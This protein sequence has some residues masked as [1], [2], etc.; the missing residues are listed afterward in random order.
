LVKGKVELRDGKLQVLCETASEYKLDDLPPAETKSE[1]GAVQIAMADAEEAA[2]ADAV[3]ELDVDH[4][5]PPPEEPPSE[6]LKER[7]VP[8]TVAAPPTA[9]FVETKQEYLAKPS[10]GDAIA[11]GGTPSHAPIRHL[12]IFLERADDHDEEV[13]RMR[14]LLNLLRSFP[15]KD[16]FSFFVPNPQGMVQLDF[17]NF[18]TS[19]QV[20]EEPLAEMV[21]EW[22][23]FEVQ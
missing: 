12:R 7:P 8:D 10:A 17:P 19:C 11:Y 16:R 5:P 1:A 18:T 23:S 14:E 6:L 15:G 13:R 22:G 3:M 4:L 2:I 20:V 9:V 21:S